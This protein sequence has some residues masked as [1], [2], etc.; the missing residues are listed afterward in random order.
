M[1]IPYN[2][3]CILWQA[4]IGIFKAKETENQELVGLPVDISIEVKKMLLFIPY[5]FYCIL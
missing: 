5:N 1:V 4:E 2:F 3:Y